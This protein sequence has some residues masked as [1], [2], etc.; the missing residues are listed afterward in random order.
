MRLFIKY[1]VSP[2]DVIAFLSNPDIYVYIYIYI[3]VPLDPSLHVTSFYLSAPL[4]ESRGYARCDRCE[5]NGD[6]LAQSAPVVKRTPNLSS[7]TS[8]GY[9]NAKTSRPFASCFALQ[10]IDREESF[11]SAL[12]RCQ[13]HRR[14][15]LQPL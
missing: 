2:N 1:L 3:F 11:V 14:Q 12:G 10:G 13:L 9:T 5:N 6:R 8:L 15:H 7:W 4:E